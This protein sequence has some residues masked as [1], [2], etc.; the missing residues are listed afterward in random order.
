[1]LEIIIDS[2]LGHLH[3]RVIL[4]LQITFEHHSEFICIGIFY[5]LLLMLVRL[6]SLDQ[7]QVKLLH[8][9]YTSSH[10]IGGNLAVLVYLLHARWIA[11][12]ELVVVGLRL[13][14]VD[15]VL[16]DSRLQVELDTLRLASVPLLSRAF[17]TWVSALEPILHWLY[18]R[19]SIHFAIFQLL[20]LI[21]LLRRDDPD[22]RRILKVDGMAC[23]VAQSRRSQLRNGPLLPYNRNT[24]NAIESIDP[25]PRYL[26]AYN[27]L[28]PYFGLL[29]LRPLLRIRPLTLQAFLDSW[30]ILH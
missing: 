6:R 23:L 12:N 15:I 3:D 14:L 5:H 27:T 4:G 29:W 20:R 26:I 8:L 1:M 13:H 17:I 21:Y 10:L 22:L 9:A 2:T 16:F 28:A 7:R 30:M 11:P 24:I 25:Y 18:C 19:R